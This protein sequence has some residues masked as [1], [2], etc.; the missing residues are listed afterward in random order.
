MSRI[1]VMLI[2]KRIEFLNEFSKVLWCNW[3][4]YVWNPFGDSDD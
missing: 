1:S 4:E 3:D 2:S